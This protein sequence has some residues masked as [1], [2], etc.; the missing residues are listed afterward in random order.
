MKYIQEVLL[1]F[2][3]CKAINHM[4]YSTY[5]NIVHKQNAEMIIVKPFFS[6]CRLIWMNIWPL[7]RYAKIYQII[8]ANW[9]IQVW[10][11]GSDY[12]LSFGAKPLSESMCWFIVKCIKSELREINAVTGERNEI[13]VN[14]PTLRM[15]SYQQHNYYQ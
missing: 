14:I 8:E 1:F 11:I 12:G 6:V 10:V 2:A 13:I 5:K 15:I 4:L 7:E 3:V 9:R